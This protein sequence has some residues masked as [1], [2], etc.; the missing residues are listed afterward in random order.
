MTVIRSRVQILNYIECRLDAFLNAID[1]GEYTKQISGS[2]S[3]T[4][5]VIRARE[6]YSKACL[7]FMVG[8]NEYISCISTK[9]EIKA[10]FES[11]EHN[12][13]QSKGRDFYITKTDGCKQ[14]DVQ[15]CVVGN[16]KHL[17]FVRD[18]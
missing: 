13:A 11:F 4:I 10:F 6:D 12:P 17:I 15:T 16:S 1:I 7:Q 9:E 5:F 8:G 3:A 14:I 2:A 18:D